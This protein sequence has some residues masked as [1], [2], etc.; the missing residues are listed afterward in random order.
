MRIAC[1]HIPQYALQ[2]VTRFDP[3]LRRTA[4]VVVGSPTP[5]IAGLQHA[6]IV[7]ACSRAAWHLGVRLGMTATVAR[8]IAPSA[9]IVGA[10]PALEHET[11]RAVAD[12]MLGLSSNVELGSRVG[13]GRA[14]LAMYV[15]VPANMRGA[16]FGNRA[17]ERLDVLGV[18][19]RIGIA[20]DRFTAWVAASHGG[21][22]QSRTGNRPGD[23]VVVPRG[24]AA[25]FLAPLPLTLL[26]I[27]TEVQHMLEALGVRTLGEFAAL[28]S[29][30]I[31]P[32]P[33]VFAADYQALA[34][35]ESG[36][37]LHPYIPR[38]VACEDIVV[39]SGNVLDIADSLS[40]P[41]AVAH[42]ARRIALRL[43]GR[44]SVA[45]RLRISATSA[46]QT[47][48]LD[49]QLDEPTAGPEQLARALAPIVA[50]TTQH[51]WTLRVVVEGERFSAAA[52]T[53][54]SHTR[55]HNAALDASPASAAAE[56]TVHPLALVLSTSG[57]LFSLSR[58][59]GHSHRR[60]RRSKP[61]RVFARSV[62]VQPTLFKNG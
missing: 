6:P 52:S 22:S 51:P 24:G 16:S 5:Q 40:G 61:R 2:C 20:D 4:A 62:D 7:I 37:S 15:E 54:D 32:R 12:A 19:C 50:G 9:S 34:R 29:P 21:F 57:A 10:E 41:T 13:A 30:S 25:A 35:G 56:S 36:T 60:T 8:S 45:T 26:Q 28:P 3:S 59:K 58:S 42:L 17:L 44:G 23:V 31:A 39:G 11:A 27:S 46:A 53:A 47:R 38:G 33:Q 43:D 14:H 18:T 55:S 49:V 48:D 1:I